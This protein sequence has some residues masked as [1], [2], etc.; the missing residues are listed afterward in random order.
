MGHAVHETAGDDLIALGAGGA[1][2]FDD[3]LLPDA[4]GMHI[5]LVGQVHQVVNHEAVVALDAAH[6]AT[7]DPLAIIG[8]MQFRQ[9]CAQ[10]QPCRLI[11]RPEASGCRWNW[12]VFMKISFPLT[13]RNFGTN[14]KDDWKS[15]EHRVFLTPFFGIYLLED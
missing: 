5:G 10:Q 8:P 7:K 2:R 11:W 6:P 12:Q 14:S 9:H 15:R 3:L 4:V 13:A 1:W